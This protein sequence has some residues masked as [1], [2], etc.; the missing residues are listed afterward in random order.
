MKTFGEQVS[1]ASVLRLA[2]SLY[3]L[4]WQ[5]LSA[6]ALQSGV[7]FGATGQIM[8]PDTIGV[9]LGR[10]DTASPA[11][12][13][14]FLTTSMKAVLARAL[15]S[16]IVSPGLLSGGSI[17]G[18]LSNSLPISLIRPGFSGRWADGG[19]AACAGASR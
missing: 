10:R 1:A 18:S 17:E 13:V 11:P 12:W 7:P 19:P 14:A 4:L 2:P 6:P 5:S 15:R 9:E 3:P 16:S 8:R